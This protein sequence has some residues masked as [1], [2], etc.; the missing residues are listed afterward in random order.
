LVNLDDDCILIY[1][2]LVRI[3]MKLSFLSF[4]LSITAFAYSQ[5]DSLVVRKESYINTPSKNSPYYPDS[6]IFSFKCTKGFG[7]LFKE[8]GS[9]YDP[10]YKIEKKTGSG[11][12]NNPIYM[13]ISV[14]IVPVFAYEEHGRFSIPADFLETGEYRLIFI[15]RIKNP[16]LSKERVAFS[17][18]GSME[19][20]MYWYSETFTIDK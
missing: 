17:N 5:N 13:K 20:D 12:V 14:M 1:I 16:I 3:K 10:F 9:G 2:V 15:K 11:W 4:L 19:N 6:I 7:I 8:D 18:F